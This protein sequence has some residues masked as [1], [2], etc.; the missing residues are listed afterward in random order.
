MNDVFK[1]WKKRV[2]LVVM[3][4]ILISGITV[5]VHEVRAMEDAVP[6]SILNAAQEEEEIS[7][8]RRA[9]SWRFTR[10]TLMTRTILALQVELH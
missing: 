2:V 6:H 1:T 5:P 4:V 7:R 10:K 9:P 3:S 8:N